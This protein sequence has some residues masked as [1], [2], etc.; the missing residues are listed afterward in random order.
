MCAAA[1]GGCWPRQRQQQRAT[2]LSAGSALRRR[3]GRD[4]ALPGRVHRSAVPPERERR[5]SSG[6][7][8]SVGQR[9]RHRSL[10]HRHL[11][12]RFHLQLTRSETL[13]VMERSALL[14][15]S[16]QLRAGGVEQRRQHALVHGHDDLQPATVR[17]GSPAPMPRPARTRSPGPT[18]H[19]GRP[20][21][22]SGDA[23]LRPEQPASPSS[24]STRTSGALTGDIVLN[25]PVAPDVGRG[26]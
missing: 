23:V 16:R 20:T 22:S 24:A 8:G 12:R 17:A 13:R 21:S 25:T 10:R 18:L 19:H 15:R 4:V 11:Q 14:P 2:E 26:R 9:R 7:P 3:R 1:A 5:P 6:L